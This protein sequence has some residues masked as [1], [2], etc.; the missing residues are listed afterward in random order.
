[1]RT[2]EPL[3]IIEAARFDIL[4]WATTVVLSV[5]IDAVLQTAASEFGV[6]DLAAVSKRHDSW[7]G[8]IALLGWKAVK[9]GIYWASDFDG[10]F[11]PR[12]P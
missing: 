11:A 6:G 12:Q 3:V 9:L 2:S 4:K 10:M 7:N 8:I 1:M 5:V